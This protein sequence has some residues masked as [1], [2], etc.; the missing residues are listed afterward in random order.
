MIFAHGAW[1][2]EWH[3]LLPYLPIAFAMGIGGAMGWLGWFWNNRAF[4]TVI[5]VLA[6]AFGFLIDGTSEIGHHLGFLFAGFFAGR[7]VSIKNSV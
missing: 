4:L 1:W 7:A 3:H 6:L 2:Q 5:A